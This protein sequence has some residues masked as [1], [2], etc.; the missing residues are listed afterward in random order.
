MRFVL[1]LV[2]MLGIFLSI[3]LFCAFLYFGFINQQNENAKIFSY[4]SLILFVFSTV[5]T[6]LASVSFENYQN[7]KQNTAI[8]NKI[9]DKLQEI[10]V[11]P[12]ATEPQEDRVTPFLEKLTAD[13]SNT[14][15][16][17]HLGFDKINKL[18]T[19]I[20]EGNSAKTLNF[21]FESLNNRLNEIQQ[22]STSQ[23]EQIFSSLAGLTTLP[24][25]ISSLLANAGN[26][27]TEASPQLEVLQ[28]TILQINDDIDQSNTQ[29]TNA[30]NM[31]KND[32]AD[33]QH[34]QLN[35]ET[36]LEDIITKLDYLL[37]LIQEMAENNVSL[38]N[39]NSQTPPIASEEPVTEETPV[40]S[41][42]VADFIAEEPVT[43]ETPVTSASVADFIVEEPVTEEAPVTSDPVADF[44]AEEPVTEEAP[45]TSDPVAEVIAEEPV[46]EEAP[47]TSDSSV[48][49]ITTEN[50]IDLNT[51]LTNDDT[52]LVSLDSDDNSWSPHEEVL[53][54]K[55]EYEAEN[56][57]GTPA[58]QNISKLLPEIE[59]ETDPTVYASDT[60]F[61]SAGLGSTENMPDLP[62]PTNPAMLESDDPYGIPSDGPMPE[63]PIDRG[64]LQADNPFGIPPTDN[65]VTPNA[66]HSQLD[67]IF[68]DQFA[69]DIA[70]LDI[71]KDD[72]NNENQQSE[73][74]DLNSLF[75]NDK[76]SQG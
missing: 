44:I 16:A 45:V 64:E 74:I 14:A 52:T 47:V 1:A 2:R 7:K 26:N 33:L 58:A 53:A 32:V 65:D 51:Y 42:S 60:P 34:K 36:K 76:N 46:T 30:I 73:E 67:A 22:A 69:A 61:G 62:A 41:A 15:E 29:T 54:D 38:I 10:H 18:L 4:G 70:D 3:C 57:F 23:T 17:I 37:P 6:S 28:R 24:E 20:Q 66:D 35:V 48:D 12:Q 43:E 31:I 11:T 50:T 5:I 68:N 59:G 75:E 21:G 55:P 40:T 27:P 63:A 13:G 25:Q 19:S 72:N 9:S 49:D 71:L 8:F 39:S 56:P